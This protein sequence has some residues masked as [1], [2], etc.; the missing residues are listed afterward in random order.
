MLFSAQIDQPVTKRTLSYAHTTNLDS[1]WVPDAAPF[2][3]QEEQVENSAAYYEPTNKT[4]FVFTNHVGI[5][6]GLE[7]TD[8][9]WVY[10]TKDLNKWSPENKAIV[11]D[12]VNCHWSK[13]I[14]GLPSVVKR[15]NRLA[16]F[17]DGNGAA[18]MPAGNNSHMRRDV[19]L[20]WLELPLRT[21]R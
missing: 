6:N 10:W 11:L 15:G 17:Y 2:L 5:R 3:P 21:P 4:W 20:A 9:I 14:I 7:Y 18:E 12:S 19:G 13:Y 16:I 8:A 1:A